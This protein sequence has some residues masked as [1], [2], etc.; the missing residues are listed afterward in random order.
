MAQEDKE[1]NTIN[2]VVDSTHGSVELEVLRTARVQEVIEASTYRLGLE[3]HEEYELTYM[4][5]TMKEERLLGSY[6]VRDGD[7]LYLMRILVGG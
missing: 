4:R 2:I 1:K 6:R 7:H 3:R 5:E